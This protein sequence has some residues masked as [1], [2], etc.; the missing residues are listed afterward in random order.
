MPLSV[1]NW[2]IRVPSRNHR[3]TSTACSCTDN[4]RVSARVP[5]RAR[6]AVSRP[7]RKFTVSSRTGSTAVYVTLIVDAEPQMKLICERTTFILGFCVFSLHPNGS[8]VSATPTTTHYP[9][10]QVVTRN[11][12]LMVS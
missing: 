1:A 6:S 12:S 9:E 7:A 10:P 2:L 5:R 3:S 11:G 4:A 8:G